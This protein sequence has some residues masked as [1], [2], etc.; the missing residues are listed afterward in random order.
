MRKPIW[1]ATALAFALASLAVVSPARAQTTPP[2][3]PVNTIF[4]GPAVGTAGQ[5]ADIVVWVGKQKVP[6]NAAQFTL[7]F[8][9]ISP[10]GLKSVPTAIEANTKPGGIFPPDSIF[11]VNARTPGVV[12]VA[13]AT[14][15]AVDGPGQLAVVQVSIPSDVPD[16]ASYAVELRDLILSSEAGEDVTPSNVLDG[17]LD[18]QG[19]AP[20]LLKGDVNGD[21]AIRVND[22]QIALRIA[23]NIITPTPQQA[24]AADVNGDGK[25]NVQDVILI[26]KAA[27]GI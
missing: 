23:V 3:I 15:H 18:I 5:T 21:G 27:L 22:A 20:P 17:Q 13:M 10:T 6:F 14:G 26:L 11:G 7:R 9:P 1:A 16:K 4:V 12:M 19:G 25:V 24:Q 2:P 8:T